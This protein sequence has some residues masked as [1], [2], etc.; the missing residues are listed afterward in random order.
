M[1]LNT[2]KDALKTAPGF[3]INAGVGPRFDTAV[4]GGTVYPTVGNFNGLP[5]GATISN[6]LGSALSA[7][8]GI[9]S[10]LY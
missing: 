1:V 6:F 2:T 9:D 7:T 8:I 4:A 5:P 3:T 10:T